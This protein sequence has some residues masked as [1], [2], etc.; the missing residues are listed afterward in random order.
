LV[1]FAVK[2]LTAKFAKRRKDRKREWDST[3][4]TAMNSSA[5]SVFSPGISL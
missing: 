3:V 2:T 1:A 4:S 5:G